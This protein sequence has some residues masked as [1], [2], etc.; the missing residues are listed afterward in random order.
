MSWKEHRFDIDVEIANCYSQIEELEN[1]I[2]TLKAKKKEDERIYR[3]TQQI[4][5]NSNIKK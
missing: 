2:K 4:S 5:N 1:K 3:L